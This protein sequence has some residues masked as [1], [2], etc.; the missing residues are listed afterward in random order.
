MKLLSTF[1]LLIYFIFILL[2]YLFFFR[3]A[4][5]DVNIRKGNSSDS[6]TLPALIPVPQAFANSPIKKKDGINSEFDEQLK[7]YEAEKT[8]LKIRK[9]LVKEELGYIPENLVTLY[10]RNTQFEKLAG[11]SVGKFNEI[12]GKQVL[13][14]DPSIEELNVDR[15]FATTINRPVLHLSS[16]RLTDPTFKTPSPYGSFKKKTG[17][18][19]ENDSKNH[20]PIIHTTHNLIKEER[21]DLSDLIL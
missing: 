18:K 4:G 8:I 6:P 1:D 19:N 2:I 17:K 21:Y 16:Q 15:R 14:N 12:T 3:V 11:T 13:L 9:N 5:L 10:V 7:S 20:L